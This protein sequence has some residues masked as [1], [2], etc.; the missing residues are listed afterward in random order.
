MKKVVFD[1]KIFYQV[2]YEDEELFERTIVN[3]ADAIFG[4][5]GIYIDIKRK[6]GKKTAAAGIPDGY[7]LDLRFH[8][9]PALYIIENELV[10]HSF[11]KHISEQ[12]SR[13]II[14]AQFDKLS[15]RELLL[16]ELSDLKYKDKLNEYYK[17]SKFDNL[18]SL[19]DQAVLKND[20]KTMVIINE[21]TDD[22]EKLPKIY[23]NNALEL[24]EFQSF[25]DGKKTIHLFDPFEGDIDNRNDISINKAAVNEIDYDKLDTIIVPAREEGFKNVFINKKCWYAIR[26]S[27]TM[28]NR[29][30]Y[31]AAYQVKPISGITYYAEVES[32]QKYINDD[33][34]ETNKYKIIF[35]DSPKK[36]ENTIKLTKDNSNIAPQ[37]PQY[38]SSDK[39]FSAKTLE[40]LF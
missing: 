5:H 23:A 14:S 10:E 20:I 36:L 34:E 2:N 39:L 12:I 26:I 30:K 27:A 3:N 37:S 1:G 15:I 28:I 25:T 19:L 9:S 35:K 18:H 11:I 16:N 38:T 4:K 7:Y 32:I 40:D 31:V 21:I 22:L 24:L 17:E 8:E 33:G 6:I 13:F 29:I